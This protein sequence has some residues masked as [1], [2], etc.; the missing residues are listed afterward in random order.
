MY[1]DLFPVIIN[2][3]SCV[4]DKDCHKMKF[5]QDIDITEVIQNY[6]LS[7]IYIL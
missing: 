2:R 3:K 5:I 4:N 7:E 1:Q 6:I